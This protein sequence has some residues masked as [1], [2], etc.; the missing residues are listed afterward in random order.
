M[1][2]LH[3]TPP[4]PFIGNDVSLTAGV[5]NAGYRISDSMHVAFYKDLNNDS[6]PQP[7]ELLHEVH[8]PPILPAQSVNAFHTVG[9][10]V[11]GLHRFMAVVSSAIDEDS[12]NNMKLIEVAVGY[13][14]GTI[15]MNE[16][17]YA[18]SNEPEWVECI[19]TATDT[20]DIRNWRVANRSPTS[21]VIISTSLPVPPSGLFLVTKDTALLRQRHPGLQ[22][23]ALQVPNMPTFLFSNTGDAVVLMDNRGV[24][25]DSVFYL[26]SWGGTGGRSLERIDP[27]TVSQDSSNWKTSTA[28]VGST[29]LRK[30]TATR[31][32]HDIAVTAVRFMPA[33]P[34][35]GDSVDVVASIQNNGLQPA[36][37]FALRF[38]EDINRDS[39]GQVNELL[40][41]LGVTAPLQ[42]SDSLQL[43]IRV[44]VGTFEERRLIVYASYPLDEDTLNNIRHALLLPRFEPGSI[45]I[46]EIMYAP[47]GGSPEWVE[48]MNV[49]ADTVDMA[50][51]RIGNRTS[52]YT[53]SA[54]PLRIPPSGF[55]VIAKDTALLRQAYPGVEP[56]LAVQVPALP[57]FLWT[58]TGD[59]VVVADAAGYLMDSVMYAPQ[60]GGSGGASLERIDL[61]LS[62]T[63]SGNWGSSRDPLGATPARQNS[64]VALDHDLK[65]A[66]A[67]EIVVA[68]GATVS[69]PVTV[70]NNGKQHGGPFTV[71]LYHDANRD[72]LTTTD[73]HI[74]TRTVQA[75][76]APRDSLVVTFTWSPPV[77]GRVLMVAVLE[78]PPDLRPENNTAYGSVNI[79]HREQSV[80]INEIMYE[81]LT[82][83]AE[84]VEFVN[85]STGAVDL[86]GWTLTDRPTGGGSVNR[87]ALA[88]SVL[89]LQSGEFF[90][91]A[92][93]SSILSLFPQLGNGLLRILN[94]SDLSLNN[95][96][97]DLVLRDQ[98]GRAIDSVAY[99][100]SW[101]NP[102][103]SDR[104]GR[105]L[106]K[107]NP[108][109]PS[110]DRRSWS[111]AAI[112][113]GG[114]PGKHNSIHAA[115]VPSGASLQ[116][117]PNPFS[118]D[119]DGFNDFTLIQYELPVEVSII[120]IKIFDAVGRV[121]RRLVNSEPAGVRGVAVWDGLDDGSQK[122]RIG[123]YI[124]LLQ[125][126]DAFGTEIYTA[127]STVVLAGR[128][129]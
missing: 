66:F 129:R 53:V 63:D 30:N 17:M 52:R 9:N 115:S 109:L 116:C 102:G 113:I 26:P 62:S 88:P 70:Y 120:S 42:P 89:V 99:S 78:Y 14:P 95:D 75:Q 107:I 108:S 34:I 32:D 3:S 123:I 87:F 23:L 72:S 47:Q 91:L 104:K 106:E 1:D 31:K 7:S 110:N 92:S 76:I 77:A 97:D 101:H 81:P 25:M 29:P 61:S 67:G 114:T 49:T 74:E 112:S 48:V 18:P 15:R 11:A 86:A 54:M 118:P 60:W 55:R 6:I 38:Y 19:N 125:A 5:L 119:G 27:L 100:P 45:R 127:K 84:Y 22:G 126:A 51:W 50:G 82:G 46:N 71:R 65:V 2:T 37:L 13:P 85:L 90:T 43:A 79:G 8:L 122:A 68:P 121:I 4:A 64:I 21:Y 28:P 59:A 111:T 36:S 93:D 69:L 20:V 98:T 16:I 105:A 12:L 128:L 57:T 96:G 35:V 83:Q 56:E 73:E 24:R 117:S 10:M 94:R 58:N 39:V 44:F 103:V 80:V 40:A 124:V 33:S 41:E